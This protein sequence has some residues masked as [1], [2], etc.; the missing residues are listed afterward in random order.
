MCKEFAE[1]IG[2]EFE[3]NMMGELNFFLGLQIKQTPTGTMIHQKKYIKELLKKFNMD[4]SKSI[5]TPIAI[6]TNLNLDEEGKIVEQNLYRG[7]IGSLLYLTAIRP[8][9]VFSVR[10]CARFQENPK[11]SHLKAV[12]RI[13]RYLKGNP[14]LCL[15]YPRG[16]NFDLVGYADVDCAEFHVDRKS[17][18]G[19][20]HCLGSFLVTKK[21]NSEVMSTAEAEYVAA[22]SCY[23]QLLWIRQQLKDCVKSDRVVVRAAA[24]GQTIVKEVVAQEESASTTTNQ[25]RLPPSK[26]DVLVSAIKVAALEIIPPM[27]DKPIVEDTALETKVTT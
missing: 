8:D 5:D 1:M 27:S 12:K 17:T 21:Q 7:M 23:A 25:V 26:L 18:L 14:D 22:P 10:L 13:L 6:A 11:E 3:M 15:W 2:N 9:I 16:Y 20:A 4:S 19:I 24:K